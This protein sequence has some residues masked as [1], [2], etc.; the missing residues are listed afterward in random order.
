[1]AVNG[2]LR[3]PERFAIDWVQIDDSGR[4]FTGEAAKL[5]N[6]RYY[7]TP[8]HSA[9]IFASRSSPSTRRRR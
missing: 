2:Q 1:M 6:W 5:A 8:I 7:G 9:L 4:A 3:V